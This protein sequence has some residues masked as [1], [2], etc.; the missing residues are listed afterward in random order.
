MRIGIICPVWFPVP[1]E[2]YGGT[3]RVVA[4]LADGLVEGGH[5]V[6]LFASGDSQSRARLESAFHTAPSEW[7]GHTYWEM[8]HALLAFGRS[9]DFDVIHDH[10]ACSGSHSAASSTSPSA[11]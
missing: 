7:I 9:Q 2:A 3:E 5:D 11:I 8:Q 1:P 4:L 10:T 6:T